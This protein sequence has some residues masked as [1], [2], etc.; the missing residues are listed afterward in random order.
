MNIRIVLLFSVIL[1]IYAQP[2]AS[3][4]I[5]DSIN[6]TFS[7]IGNLQVFFIDSITSFQ[8]REIFRSLWSWPRFLLDSNIFYFINELVDITPSNYQEYDFIVVGAGSA[9]SALA[10][11]LS[12]NENATVLLIEAGGNELLLMDV[13]LFAPVLRNIPSINWNYLTEPSDKYCRGKKAG[14]CTATMGKV[15]GGSSTV[16]FMIALRGKYF[17]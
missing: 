3:Q 12:E 17:I 14:S 1:A 16:N 9:G 4:T 10:A 8:S 13:P 6:S 5:W 15:L 11:R 2:T 7:T